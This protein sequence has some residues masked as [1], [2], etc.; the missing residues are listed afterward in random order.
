M[1]D[2]INIMHRYRDSIVSKSSINNSFKYESVGAY[3]MFPCSDE[4]TFEENKY[5]KSIEKVNIGALPMLPGCTSL[6]KKHLCDIINE[7]YM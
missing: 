7:S 5:Y 3:V 1:E 4:K 2:D 6:M